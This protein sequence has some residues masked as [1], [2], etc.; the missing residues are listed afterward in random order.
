LLTLYS[1]TKIWNEAFWKPTPPSGK[2]SV[3]QASPSIWSAAIA[4]TLI[5]VLM[6]FAGQ[7]LYEVTIQAAEQL[8][9]S[10]L[11]QVGGGTP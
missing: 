6:G 5:V 3:G 11:V 8:L 9:N 2:T 10:S 4:L 7:P 1:M